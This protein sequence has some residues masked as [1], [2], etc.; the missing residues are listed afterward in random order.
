[1]SANSSQRR[2]RHGRGLRRPVHSKVFRRGMGG[3]SFFEQVVE[4]TCEYLKESFPE[5][6]GNLKIR[7]EDMP[8]LSANSDEVQRYELDQKT[9]T[10]TLYRVPIQRMNKVKYAD[11]Q[12]QIERVVFSAAAELINKDPWDLIHPEN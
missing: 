6:L 11:P 7:I 10:V 8:A 1:M 9:M 4:E 12:M 3:E 2:D 5:E